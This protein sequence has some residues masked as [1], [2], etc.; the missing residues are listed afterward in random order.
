MHLASRHA[1]RAVQPCLASPPALPPAPPLLPR[2]S[3]QVIKGADNPLARAA[4]AG[5][6]TE[7]LHAAAAHDLDQLQ[8]LAVAE[9]TLA[10]WV[11]DTAFGLSGEW[12]GAASSLAPAA[13]EQQPEPVHQALLAA[14]Q[15]SP[16][17]AAP[18]SAAQRAG[19]RA[20][21]ASKWRWSEGV[22][23]RCPGLPC[24]ISVLLLLPVGTSAVHLPGCL[25][26]GV[27]LGM[28]A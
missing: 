4:A 12:L 26:D 2:P 19:L 13:P 5:K 6:P 27:G 7:H 17:L 3:L 14:A 16:T 1:A 15:L 11:K 28:F 25:V 20:E 21:L 24:L 23:V 8:Q 9:T 10:G 22:E 18:L